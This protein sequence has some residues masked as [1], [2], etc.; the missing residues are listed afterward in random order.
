MQVSSRFITYTEQESV[1]KLIQ[2]IQED[3]HILGLVQFGSSLVSDT[4]RDIDLCLITDYNSIPPEIMYKYV[5]ILPEP[6]E[7]HFFSQL[8]LYIQSE[9]VHKGT[10]LYKR[11][12]NE[13]FDV[14]ADFIQKYN[15]YE[16]RYRQY[17]ELVL[18]D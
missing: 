15:S 18:H 14:Y 6:F 13:L 4:Y 9:V 8:P 12:F 1:L 7:M 17:L 5:V 2:M 16:P 11:D 3:F 10:V